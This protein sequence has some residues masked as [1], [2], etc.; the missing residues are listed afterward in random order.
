M[1]HSLVQHI[2]KENCCQWK[3]QRDSFGC[4][5]IYPA[6]IKMGVSK[7]NGT[8]KSSILIGFG[9]IIFTIH[10]GGVYIP[11]I[12]GNTQMAENHRVP[13]GP[14]SPVEQTH[15]VCKG[16]QQSRRTSFEREEQ[17]QQ[18]EE[19]GR[20][21]QAKKLYYIMIIIQI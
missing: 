8:P 14:P 21:G 1:L 18:K 13:L 9:T 20:E 7:N 3:S 10:F 15:A 6:N 16:P 5:K 12:F 11:P 2:W 17:Q 4:R 19:K